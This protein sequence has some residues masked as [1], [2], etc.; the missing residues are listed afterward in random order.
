MPYKNCFSVVSIGKLK[1]QFRDH[2]QGHICSLKFVFRRKPSTSKKC[3]SCSTRFSTSKGQR[4]VRRNELAGELS[5]RAGREISEKK[6]GVFLFII[7]SPPFHYSVISFA[8]VVL[9]RTARIRIK[10]HHRATAAPFQTISS[11]VFI[12]NI[13]WIYRH[14]YLNT[15]NQ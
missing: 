2:E 8:T 1:R 7:S 13:L 14:D 12:Y 6:P 11:G 4:A 15:V 9:P 10:K 5:E 3:K